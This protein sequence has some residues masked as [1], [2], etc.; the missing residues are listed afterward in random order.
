[1]KEKIIT[2]QLNILTEEYLIEDQL[3]A[4]S[5]GIQTNDYGAKRT[6]QQQL[7]LTFAV[8]EDAPVARWL[9]AAVAARPARFR[10]PL[11][12]FI[13]GPHLHAAL[14]TGTVSVVLFTEQ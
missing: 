3:L 6:R 4:Q 5:N 14:F 12:A 1:M 8:D 2:I 13:G 7:C 11:G 10:L 9:G